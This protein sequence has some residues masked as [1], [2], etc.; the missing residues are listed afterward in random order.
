M[1][2]R[3]QMSPSVQKSDLHQPKAKNQ[4]QGQLAALLHG[5]LDY[6]DLFVSQ[7]GPSSSSSSNSNVA[8]SLFP[9]DL[10]SNSAPPTQLL[11]PRRGNN[12]NDA[13]SMDPE[14][15]KYAQDVNSQPWQLWQNNEEDYIQQDSRSNSNGFNAY[16]GRQ[17]PT[18]QQE[19][20]LASRRQRNLVDLIQQDFPRTPSPLF[21]LQQQAR[22][23]HAAAAAA[24]AAGFTFED[25]TNDLDAIQKQ[26]RDQLS[27]LEYDDMVMRRQ[28]DE[29]NSL[30]SPPLR[31]KFVSTPPARSNSTPPG[32]YNEI[33]RQTELM[34]NSFSGFGLNEDDDY[35][36]LSNPLYLQQLQQQQQS[37]SRFQQH[38]GQSSPYGGGSPYYSNAQ[39]HN[40]P[41]Q[42]YSPAL[43]LSGG[44]DGSDGLLGNDA[45]YGR[46]SQGD[47]AYRRQQ[48]QGK[49][50]KPNSGPITD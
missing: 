14:Q 43:E 4:P 42:S 38:Q 16:T 23:R 46:W 27:A 20:T 37:A 9:D 11:N 28:S 19:D 12:M 40:I 45:M 17:T 26:Y 49:L 34:M 10:R 47:V 41:Q 2:P 33:D 1:L 48:Q 22:Q 3:R 7:G 13:S 29:S 31:N 30:I 25:P 15:L 44:L 32:R 21:A 5:K 35:N 50:L 36:M 24:A 18:K 8:S 39:L 6:D